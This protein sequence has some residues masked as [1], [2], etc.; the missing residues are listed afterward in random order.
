MVRLVKEVV[1]IITPT[2]NASRFIQETIKS[3]QA[4]SYPYWE[5]IIV[6]D[7]STDDTINKIKQEIKFDSRIHLL[8][9]AENSGPAQARNMAI[10]AAKGKYLAFLDSDD[11]WLPYKLERQLK[12]M[13]ANNA[14]FTYSDY[15]IM[16]ENGVQSEIVFRVPS[17]IVYKDLLK[18]TM[19]GTL[20]VMLDKEI[21][22]NIQMP[23][24][25]DCSED[26]GLWLSILSKG[27]C[28]YG[29]NEELA[30]YRKCKNSLSSN[31]FNSAL[32][33]WNTYRKVERINVPSALWYFGN[34]F[35]HAFK[36]HSR[37][38]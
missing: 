7:C 2:Y 26:Y 3:V 1:S 15:R 27:I 18:N 6:D 24:L 33:T 5:M 11:L 12:F 32:K 29:I 23:I 30:V 36:K 17:K 16:D 9:L 8:E 13:K 21:V 28:A 10:K 19:I 4:Q 38:Y 34:Y 25:R 14:A 35:V 20:T 37:S 22:G 31:K